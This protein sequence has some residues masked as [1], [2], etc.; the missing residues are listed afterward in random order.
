MYCK[1]FLEKYKEKTVNRIAVCVYVSISLC[2]YLF[3][4]GWCKKKINIESDVLKKLSCGKV[5]LFYYLNPVR[6]KCEYSCNWNWQ[7]FAILT[8]NLSS[9]HKL[10]NNA[11][12]VSVLFTSNR[13]VHVYT[14][15]CTNDIQKHYK[16][17]VKKQALACING[18]CCIQIVV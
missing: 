13:I 9:I 6:E 7:A 16:R 11:T 8:A 15:L 2:A 14:T 10:I 1:F 12:L 4:V 3:S 18:F 17:N 5:W